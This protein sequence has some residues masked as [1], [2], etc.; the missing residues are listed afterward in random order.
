MTNNTSKPPEDNDARSGLMSNKPA[1]VMDAI[2]TEAEGDALFDELFGVIDDDIAEPDTPRVSALVEAQQVA[3]AQ[4]SSRTGDSGE[5]QFD[6]AVV[7]P[8]VEDPPTPA[9]DDE[10]THA[11]T[12][13]KAPEEGAEP[14][15]MP[16]QIPPSAPVRGA[17]ADEQIQ[18]Q[19]TATPPAP[20]LGEAVGLEADG[21]P[22]SDFTDAVRPT[23]E[24]QLN[25][26]DAVAAQEVQLAEDALRDKAAATPSAPALGQ[27]LN[28]PLG[29]PPLPARPAALD[30][31]E[32]EETVAID[33]AALLAQVDELT[34]DADA[35]S[36]E[37]VDGD[38]VSVEPE[39]DDV[40]EQ[41]QAAAEL[42][43]EAALV[44][45]DESTAE[46]D[47]AADELTAPEVEPDADE[48]AAAE[49]EP[50]AGE[51]AAEVEADAGEVAVAEIEVDA[52]ELTVAEV[53]VDADELTVAEVEVDAAAYEHD[54]D[55][56]DAVVAL[57]QQ[58]ARDAWVDRANWLYDEAP[59]ATDAIERSN[60]LLVVSEIFAMAGERERAETIAREALELAPSSPLAHRQLRGILM[61]AG[62]WSDV[63]DALA[64]EARVARTI[65]EPWA[66]RR[67]DASERSVCAVRSTRSA[68]PSY[69][70]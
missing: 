15:E 38:A 65:C 50:D 52:D 20:T 27:P 35:Q 25:A 30:H 43:S 62:R 69:C 57:M 12:D 58:G 31:D 23:A 18:D 5:F 36:A 13:Q 37:P 42:D 68:P 8:E 45:P 4:E 6:E 33:G 59:E 34:A 3:A 9:V 63:T 11:D 26:T 70:A 14:Y 40:A 19:V 64:A 53:E 28:A 61:S 22:E 32:E 24:P 2:P 41:E 1:T 55:S 51:L 10:G 60:A 54:G 49:V 47:E 39:I 44:E 17:D 56:V 21:G 67:S 29:P 16:Y 66:S 48:L 7:E 46:P